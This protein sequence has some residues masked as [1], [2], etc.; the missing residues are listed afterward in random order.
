MGIKTDTIAV[1]PVTEFSAN[2]KSFW[3]SSLEKLLENHPFLEHPHKQ[4]FYM[5]LF[6]ERADSYAIVDDKSIRLD[7]PKVICI[8][9]NSVFSININRAAKG[10]IIC[11]T[12]DFFS[13]RYNN[14]VLFQF[15]F[16]KKE[17]ESYVRFSDK[18]IE[19]WNTILHL[20]QEEITTKQ[21]GVE[22]LLRSYLNILL[23]DLDRKFYR[24]TSAK[25]VDSK[26]EKII[27]FEKLLE[28]SFAHQKAPS[29]YATKLHVTTNYLNKLCNGIRGV[30]SGELIRMRVAMEAQ[31]LLHYTSRSVAEIAN[32]LGFESPSYFATFFK[33]NTG[34][35]PESFRKNNI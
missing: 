3:F 15:A 29:Y 8:K 34:T 19:K 30:T 11:F 23:Y 18:Q 17:A 4:S 24:H 5:L 32:E 13:L 9:P 21:S 27:Q 10:F 31:R 12:E 14:N 33:K 7:E 26:E 28:E 1:Y 20:M 16:L 35:T 6:V 25:K 22:K 2:N